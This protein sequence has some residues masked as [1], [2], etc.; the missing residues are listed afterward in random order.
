MQL[1]LQQHVSFELEWTSR[2]LE[3]GYATNDYSSK[4]ELA[5]V[6]IRAGCVLPLWRAFFNVPTSLSCCLINGHSVLINIIVF[7]FV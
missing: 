1:L 7:S 4:S 2:G 6:K 3:E 5:I